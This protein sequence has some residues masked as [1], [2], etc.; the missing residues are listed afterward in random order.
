MCTEEL[1]R[2]RNASVLIYFYS[3]LVWWKIYTWMNFNCNDWIRTLESSFSTNI[4][5]LRH[6]DCCK[7]NKWSMF[8][9]RKRIFKK[10][11]HVQLFHL[12][13]VYISFRFFRY[14]YTYPCTLVSFNLAIFKTSQKIYF[15]LHSNFL[16]IWVIRKINVN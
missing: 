6:T 9:S 4:T 16:P 8:F 11:H 15:Q 12:L 5:G 13:L 14:F 3:C 7:S 10:I 2:W 1:W